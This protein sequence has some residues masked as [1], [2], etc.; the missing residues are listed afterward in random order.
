[1]DAIP[2][3][4]LC[5]FCTQGQLR[6]MRCRSCKKIVAICDECELIWSDIPAVHANA[7]VKSAGAHPVCPECGEQQTSWELLTRSEISDNGMD[8]L[9][10]E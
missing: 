2:Y 4:A 8:N 7:E 9:L 10:S 5:H 6:P 3:I 1:M